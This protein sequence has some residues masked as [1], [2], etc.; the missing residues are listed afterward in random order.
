[1]GTELSILLVTAASLAFIHTILGPDHYIPFVMMARARKWSYT[2]TGWITF[3]CGLGHVG[4]SVILGII[5]ISLGLALSNVTSVE[6][7]RGNIAAWV[8]M[9]FGLIY[10]AWGLRRAIKGKT[11]THKHLHSNG[12]AHSHEHKHAGE[13]A[14]VHD[15][16]DGKDGKKEIT[17]WILFT[18][19]ILGPCEP[20]IPILMYPAAKSSWTD[21][22]LVAGLFSLVT[23]ATMMLSVGLILYGSKFLPKTNIIERY[24]H[25]IAGAIICF[26]GVSIQFL[27]L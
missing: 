21:V 15:S 4:S 24:M 18:I 5:G 20:L 9:G 8:L 25:A 6:G 12:T 27:G 19:F 14:H 22:A 26:C 17:P 13:H 16:T 3:A 10:F 23:I 1:M 11:H 2:K 7:F